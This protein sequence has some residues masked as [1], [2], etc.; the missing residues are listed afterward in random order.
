MCTG[1][2]QKSW[3]QPA[4]LIT[5]V[6]PIVIINLLP[7]HLHYKI[8]GAAAGNTTEVSPGSESSMSSA[9]ICA[10]ILEI[11][12]ALEASFPD[13]V[14]LSLSLPGITVFETKLNFVD[15]HDRCLSLSVSVVSTLGGRKYRQITMLHRRLLNSIV[16]I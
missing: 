14:T 8:G 13:P 16:C 9:D 10:P 1:P 15:S 5:F 3:I 11:A 12:F 4:H 7:C 6:S 2:Q